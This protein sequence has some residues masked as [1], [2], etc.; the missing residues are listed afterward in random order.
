MKYLRTRDEYKGEFALW[1]DSFASPNPADAEL[2]APRR[3]NNRPDFSEPLGGLLA[4]LGGLFEKDVA[5]I[6]VRGGLSS[7]ESVL[8][9][10]YVLVPHDVIVPDLLETTDIPDLAAALTPTNLRLEALVDN[11][12][13]RLSQREIESD[14]AIAL[15]TFQRDGKERPTISENVTSPAKWLSMSPQPK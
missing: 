3:V 12:N 11:G 2:L 14:Y 10:P 7:F 4:M 15:A 9:A 6:Y 1:G 5:A 8:T 13:Q